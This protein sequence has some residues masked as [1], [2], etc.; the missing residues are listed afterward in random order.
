[1]RQNGGGS[2]F[3]ADQMAAYFFDAPLELGK[4]GYYDESLGE[5]YFDPDRTDRFYLP[6]ESL[7][8]SGPVAVVT[9]PNCASACEFFTHDMALDGRAEIVAHYP[10]AGLGGAQ[11]FFQHAGL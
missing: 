7:R 10:T 8:Y 9:G 4:T 3:L 5:F 2:G 6:D 1:M 11:N